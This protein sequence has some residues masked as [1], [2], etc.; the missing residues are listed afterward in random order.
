M[1]IRKLL[2]AAA[3]TTA[4]VTTIGAAPASART[5]PPGDAEPIEA[6]R[7][8]CDAKKGLWVVAPFSLAR[9][10]SAIPV[11]WDRT[12]ALEESICTDR[13][14]GRFTAVPTFGS[15]NRVTWACFAS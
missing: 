12:F 11:G 5:V 15:R 1:R 4:A 13:L 8:L 3:I 14:G 7:L 10:Q 9:C 6:L 2:A